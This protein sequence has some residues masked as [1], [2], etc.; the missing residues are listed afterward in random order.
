VEVK[1]FKLFCGPTFYPLGGY[2]DFKGCFETIEHAK[3]WLLQH[4]PDACFMWAHIVCKDEI[5]L[6]GDDADRPFYGDLSPWVWRE[7]E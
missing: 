3:L 1:R 7:K 5:V 2:E 6:W 4:S